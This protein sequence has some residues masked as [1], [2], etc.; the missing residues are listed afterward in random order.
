MK[1]FPKISIVTPSFNDVEFLEA[2]ILS[3]IN[4]GY[5]NLE[6]IVIDGGSTDGSVE[7]IR[8]YESRLTYWISERDSG[9]YD[10]IQK[11]F[12]K[13]T[14]EVMGW[15]NSDDMLH[16]WSLQ[17]I[18]QIFGD[19]PEVHWIQGHPNIID[20]ENRVVSVY[21]WTEI[22]KL[23]FYRSNR[24]IMK[25][26]QQEST[27]WSRSLW[28][29][30]GGYVSTKYKLAGDFELWLRFFKHEK[31]YFVSVFLGGF[32]ISSHGQASI[33]NFDKYV[34][35]TRL[36]L[37]ENPISS[38]E[39]RLLMIFRGFQFIENGMLRLIRSI[40]KVFLHG[41]PETTSEQVYFDRRSQNLKF[42]K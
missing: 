22:D 19:F 35:E 37:Q 38:K 26:I 1:L 15:I 18:A 39:K 17:T 4:Q 28:Q 32:R 42:R 33:E 12:E 14:G 16:P 23:Y 7:I 29:R 9:M 30:S 36:A 8:K 11:G 27:F 21:R 20:E 34:Q 41:Y 6:Y 3:V 2:T 13:S 40:R 31:L 10:A 25:Y 24:D 5:P